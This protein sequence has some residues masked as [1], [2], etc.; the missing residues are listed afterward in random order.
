MRRVCGR[1]SQNKEF[2]SA[3]W[4]VLYKAYSPA[5]QHSVLAKE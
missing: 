3:A 2:L 1:Q 5:P 4:E